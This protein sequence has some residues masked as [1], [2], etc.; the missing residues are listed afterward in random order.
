M[1]P[2][3]EL[4]PTNAKLL[5][6]LRD[7]ADQEAW[8]IFFDTYQKFIYK[9]AL[10]AGLNDAEAQD[11]VQET[12]ISV[13]KAMPG[14]T[15]HPDHGSFKSWLLKRAGWRIVDE[16][17]KRTPNTEAEPSESEDNSVMEQI[18]DP[19]SEEAEARWDEEWKKSLFDAARKQ[20]KRKTE[21]Q[22]YQIFDLSTRKGWSVEKISRA[23]EISPEKVYMARHRVK[24]MIELEIKKMQQNDLIQW[25]VSVASI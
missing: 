3:D 20:V 7:S 5:D 2:A 10:K 25:A 12:V 19:V 18:T 8:Q 9:A 6:R 21:P 23:M 22:S 24:Q 11:A 17:R 14:F 4:I 13:L 1:D 16:L 15:Y